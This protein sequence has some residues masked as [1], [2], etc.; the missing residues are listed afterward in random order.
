[1]TLLG[2]ADAGSRVVS[3]AEYARHRRV[4]R[5]AINAL[6]KSG[7]LRAPAV[8]SNGTIDIDMA[9]A[10][11]AD[12]QTNVVRGSG[13]ASARAKREEANARL[14]ELALAEKEGKLVERARVE[15][16]AAELGALIRQRLTERRPAL[17]ATLQ[18]S[19][20]PVNALRE[21]DDALCLSLAEAAEARLA[22]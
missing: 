9:D 4:T 1:M 15:S 19:P 21:L 2:D 11:L 6:V 12:P 18:T 8:L 16:C 13:M 14:A 5:Q 22:A 20:D 3:Q 7:R 17:I 10:M